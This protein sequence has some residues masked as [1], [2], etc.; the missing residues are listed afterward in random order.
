MP[1]LEKRI[2]FKGNTLLKLEKEGAIDVDLR[3]GDLKEMH[4]LFGLISIVT[5]DGQIY[6]PEKTYPRLQNFCDE[7]GIE[8]EEHPIK[9]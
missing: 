6:V 9:I 2:T 8:Y 3:L 5:K 7:V 1:D 4:I